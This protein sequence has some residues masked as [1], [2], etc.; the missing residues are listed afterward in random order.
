MIMRIMRKYFGYWVFAL[1]L[2]TLS[3]GLVSGGLQGIGHRDA[4]AVVNGEGIPYEHFSDLVRSVEEQ[5]RAS[6]GKDLSDAELSKLRRDAMDQMIDQT[7]ALQGMKKL[8]LSMSNDEVQQ[9]LLSMPMFKD[10]KGNYSPRRY[11]QYLQGQISRGQTV[12]QIEDSIVRSLSLN[13]AQTFWRNS[14]KVTPAELAQGL[15]LMQ[16]R[17]KA[18]LIVWGVK[19]L[20]K[21]QAPSD[22]DLHAYYSQNRQTWVKPEQLKARHIL[23]KADA[24]LGTG[25]AKAKADALYKRIQAGEDFAKLAREN[26]DDDGTAK[27][28]GDLGYFAKGDMVPE[29]EA[30]AFKLKVGEVGEPVLSKFGWHII[31]VEG[32]KPGFEPTFENSKAKV[33]DGLTAE[34]AQKQAAA[35]AALALKDLQDGKTLDEAAK[36]LKGQ[37]KET[38]WFKLEDKAILPGLGDSSKLASELLTLDKGAMLAAAVQ[39]EKGTVLGGLSDAQAGTPVTDAD[40]LAKRRAEVL[41]RLRGEKAAALYD[42]W[43]KGLRAEAKIDDR[44]ETYYGA[45]AAK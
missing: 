37:L 16:R 7:L 8:N 21:L 4:I 2:L 5:E 35:E 38:G 19:D 27:K 25:T 24:L 43:I 33:V 28:G 11:E 15:A 22:D 32:K 29:F 44:F 31:K 10:E 30:S 34:L 18:R 40:K 12:D 42:G 9:T 14:A 45:L 17:A 39:L 3:I 13:K 20:Q 1:L 41:S 36:G 6:R 23:I 26:S